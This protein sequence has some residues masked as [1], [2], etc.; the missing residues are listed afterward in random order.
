[1]LTTY[2][3]LCSFPHGRGFSIIIFFEIL[4]LL[5]YDVILKKSVYVCQRCCVVGGGENELLTRIRLC[6]QLSCLIEKVVTFILMVNDL[7]VNSAHSLQNRWSEQV[8]T[9]GEMPAFHG[10]RI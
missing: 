9:A 2:M 5:F 10:F 8:R 7:S 4:S 6:L 1:M 3:F